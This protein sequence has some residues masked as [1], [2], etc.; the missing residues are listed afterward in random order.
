M[1]LVYHLHLYTS[2]TGFRAGSHTQIKHTHQGDSAESRRKNND[3]LSNQS[4]RPTN[5]IIM[6]LPDDEQS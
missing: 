2:G 4:E 3:L 1:P 5:D 6:G